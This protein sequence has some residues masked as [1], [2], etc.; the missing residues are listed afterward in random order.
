MHSSLANFIFRC[1]KFKQQ[2]NSE[3]ESRNL[4]RNN[5]AYYTFKN[6]QNE[7]ADIYLE[8]LANGSFGIYRFTDSNGKII[9]RWDCYTNL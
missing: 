1:E 6:K 7:K 9:D 4:D 3:L 5:K 8:H 2:T